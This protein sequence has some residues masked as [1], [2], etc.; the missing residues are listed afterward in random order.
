MTHIRPSI[1]NVFTTSQIYE[2]K[3]PVEVTD[4]ETSVTFSSQRKAVLIYNDGPND[5]HF[6]TSPGVST[7][8]FKIPSLAS[9]SIVFP[10][11]TLYFICASGQRATLYIIGER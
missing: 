9:I 6:S 2:D 3:S 11:T 4:Q 10:V 1:I 5:V 7:S 8:S